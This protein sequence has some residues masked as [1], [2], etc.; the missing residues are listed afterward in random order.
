MPD[1][2]AFV[3]VKRAIVALSPSEIGFLRPWILPKCDLAGKVQAKL[4][5]TYD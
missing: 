4:F 3:A 2:E 5:D 1:S